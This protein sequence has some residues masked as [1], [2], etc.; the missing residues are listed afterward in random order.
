MSN[1]DEVSKA[2][3]GLQSDMRHVRKINESILEKTDKMNESVIIQGQ[4]VAAA[5]VRLDKMEPKVRE[6]EELKN[7][8]VGF[9]LAITTAISSASGVVGSLVTKFLF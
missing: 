4:K 7:K 8:G 1:L 5:H 2:L 9:W 6:H 3:G